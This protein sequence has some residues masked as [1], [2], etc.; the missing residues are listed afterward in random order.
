MTPPAPPTNAAQY[1]GDFSAAIAVP[2]A[3]SVVDD[4][5]GLYAIFIGDPKSLPEPFSSML[6]RRGT[7]LLYEKGEARRWLGGWGGRHLHVS[8]L[9]I[10]LFFRPEEQTTEAGNVGFSGT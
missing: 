10:C 6:I 2:N 5:P 7:R 4:K 1:L 8:C 3:I 9:F